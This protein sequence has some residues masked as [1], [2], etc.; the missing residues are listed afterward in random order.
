MCKKLK[1]IGNSV[2]KQ[3]YLILRKDN[4]ELVDQAVLNM[5]H[6]VTRIAAHCQGKDMTRLF[7]FMT[8]QLRHK[9]HRLIKQVAGLGAKIL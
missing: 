4:C 7:F 8:P 9:Q 2:L 1:F 3:F 5:P 6:I